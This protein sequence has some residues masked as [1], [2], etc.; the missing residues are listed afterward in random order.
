MHDNTP[1]PDD[2]WQKFRPGPYRELIYGVDAALL[3][4]LETRPDGDA[5]MHARNTAYSATATRLIL[6]CGLLGGLTDAEI[7]ETGEISSSLVSAYAELFFDVRP[8]LEDLG[9]IDRKAIEQ[10]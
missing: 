4:S 10:L 7:C 8:H 5:V 2:V 3:I 9:W 1:S 6:E